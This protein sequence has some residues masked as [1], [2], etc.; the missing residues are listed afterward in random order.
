MR[1]DK[2]VNIVTVQKGGPNIKD[3]TMEEAKS[4]LCLKCSGCFHFSS[5][6]PGEK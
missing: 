3:V 4:N 5:L 2:E 6:F 1:R